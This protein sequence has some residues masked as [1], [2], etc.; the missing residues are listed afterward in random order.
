M[1]A[2]GGHTE[3]GVDPVSALDAELLAKLCSIPS[4]VGASFCSNDLRKPGSEPPAWMLSNVAT[5]HVEHTGQSQASSA[6]PLRMIVGGST[7]T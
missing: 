1:G 5:P 3:G 4:H 6:E 2:E 7:C